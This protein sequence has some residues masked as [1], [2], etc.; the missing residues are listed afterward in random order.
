MNPVQD[1][2]FYREK[3]TDKIMSGG[4]K[5]NS[6]LI[7]SSSNPVTALIVLISLCVI[8][9]FL[10]KLSVSFVLFLYAVLV[11]PFFLGIIKKAVL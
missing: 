9:L 8:V 11:N 10:I 3:G 1:L 4:Y 2:V 6:L 5:I 7:S